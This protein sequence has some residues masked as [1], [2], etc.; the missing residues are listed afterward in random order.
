M[1]VIE[2]IYK[3]V[4]YYSVIAHWLAPMRHHYNIHIGTCIIIYTRE[5]RGIVVKWGVQMVIQE[6]R[7]TKQG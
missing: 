4:Y 3:N 2:I 6:K 5:K 1:Y 7:E